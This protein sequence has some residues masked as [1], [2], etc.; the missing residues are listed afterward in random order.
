[1]PCTGPTV[2]TSSGT[3]GPPLAPLGEPATLGVVDGLALP[4][5]LADGDCV[6][7]GKRSRAS[8][9]RAVSCGAPAL[10]TRPFTPTSDANWRCRLTKRSWPNRTWSAGA[11]RSHIASKL[12]AFQSARYFCAVSAAAA[13]CGVGTGVGYGVGSGPKEQALSAT[14][15][16]KAKARK[17]DGRR[18]DTH[19]PRPIISPALPGGTPPRRGSRRGPPAPRRFG[20]ASARFPQSS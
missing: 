18:A 19:S 16:V 20:E 8:G 15:P 11:R 12:P 2:T 4:E 9:G 6:G 10:A 3:D 5:A 1:M 14:N 7:A 13:A 17:R